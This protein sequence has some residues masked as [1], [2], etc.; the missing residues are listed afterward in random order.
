MSGAVLLLELPGGDTVGLAFPTVDAARAWEDAAEAAGTL[1][2][3][4][5]G[6][7]RLVT[8]NELSK[9]TR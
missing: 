7:V 4:V 5:R 8:R 6:C 3:E 9:E 2:A 1:N